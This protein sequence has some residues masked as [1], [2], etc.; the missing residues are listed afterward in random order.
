[1]SIN[2]DESYLVG[3]RQEIQNFENESLDSIIND[4]P[5][6]LNI[7]CNILSTEVEKEVFLIGA[8]GIISGILPNVIARYAGDWIGPNLF[9]YVIGEYGGGKGGL[10]WAKALANSIHLAKKDERKILLQEYLKDHIIYK[11][12]L[13]LFNKSKSQSEPPYAPKKPP[14]K[15][16]FIPVNNSKSGVYQLLEDNSSRGIM[17]ETEGDTLADALKQEY[18]NYS[19]LL[20][21]TFHHESLD[22]FRRENNESVDIIR[23]HLSVVLSSTPDQLKRLIPSTEDGLYSRFLYYYLKPDPTFIDV[24]DDRMNNYTEQFEKFS[25]QFKAMFDYLENIETPIYIKLDRSH[26]LEF[27]NYFKNKKSSMI[28]GISHSMA[29]TANRFGIIAFRIMMILTAL[30]AFEQNNLQGVVDCNATDYQNAIRIV[31]RLE[32]HAIRVYEHLGQTP[33]NKK[34]ALK[35]RQRGIS[36]REIEKI[37]KINRGTLSKWFNTPSKSG[38]HGNHSTS[39]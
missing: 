22:F 21:K 12:E 23:P 37:T 18:G 5:G 6:M 16:L 27:V 13:S 31:E 36:L 25:M 3:L 39:Q 15:M 33:D 35:L 29:G 26:Q 17:F 30:R 32:I 28:E 1:M 24:F 38:N 19:D 4:L 34:L 2:Q 11:K 10:K 9:V 8:I 7:P 14:I 20:R